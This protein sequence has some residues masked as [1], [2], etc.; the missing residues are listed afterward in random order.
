MKAIRTS[1]ASRNLESKRRMTQSERAR[2]Q[3]RDSRGRFA[4]FDTVMVIDEFGNTGV[5]SKRSERKFGYAVSLT[6]RPDDFGRVTEMNRILHSG[7]WK[8]T[9]DSIEERV[10]K[11][12]GIARLGVQT[13]AYYVDKNHPPKGWN[14][15]DRG[16]VM[17]SILDYSITSSLPETKG[18]VLVVVDHHNAY[19][20][21]IKPLIESKSTPW[22]NV[23]GDHFRS[24]RGTYAD[25]LQTQ[26]YVANAARG[27]L[28]IGDSKRTKILKM[29]IHKIQGGDLDEF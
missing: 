6:D 1:A 7:E 8:S 9:D 3:P 24:D 27:K 17:R 25:L 10:R 26:D 15:E 11:T 4:G 16:K 2:V 29:R 23:E 18:N 22:K 13:F 19:K 28:E 21:K 20:G 14:G 12:R 5:E